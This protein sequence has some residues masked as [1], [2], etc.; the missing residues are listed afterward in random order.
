MGTNT[1][2]GNLVGIQ[3]FMHPL[4]YSSTQTYCAKLAGYLEAAQEEGWLTPK[5]VIV[6]PEYL[7]AW[8][9]V[10]GEKRA[11]HQ[12][13][14]VTQAM[15]TLILTHLFSFTRVL[16]TAKVRPRPA[17]AIK[18]S[19][20]R[21]K[22]ARMAEIYQS[23]FSRLAREYK[24]TIVAGSIILPSPQILE[25]TLTAGEGALM[26]VSMVFKPDGTAHDKLARKA[27]PIEDELPFI[28]AASV[29]EAPIFE[30]PAGRLAVLVCA[31]SW[32]PSAYKSVQ[33]KE[34]DLIVVPTYLATDHNW[35]KLW[36][37]YNGAPP[38]H[39][40]DPADVGLLTEGEAWQK[41]ALP[42]RMGDTGANYGMNV[43][44]RGKLWDLGSDGRTLV[45]RDNNLAKA[46]HTPGATVTNCWIN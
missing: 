37:G 16:L 3:P 2:A 24:V 30:T 17:D 5:T 32:Y 42:G 7:G 25:G 43:F 19:L 15:K 18:D 26:N 29:S 36:D 6:F 10:A 14:S 9:V 33:V 1:G 39:D 8:L 21:L 20:F 45:V 11:V 31:D 40:V 38:P 4:D 22:A 13:D 12:A 28:A 46:S 23:V 27:F 35:D 44:L 41:Y 34:P